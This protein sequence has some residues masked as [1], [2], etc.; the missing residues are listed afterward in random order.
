LAVVPA[1]EH[2]AEHLALARGQPLEIAGEAGLALELRAPLGA[3]LRRCANRLHKQLVVERLLDEVEGSAL[4]R[5]SRRRD[6]AVRGQHHDWPAEPPSRE[7]A[8][9]VDARQAGHPQ[10]E[11]HAVGGLRAR[12]L[13][14]RLARRELARREAMQAQ[15]QR[16][17]IAHG[18]VVV[19]DRDQRGVAR[20]HCASGTVKQNA[21]PGA[22]VSCQ[23]RPPC[24]S[25]IER[26]I[27]SPSPVPLAFVI[28][29][30]SNSASAISGEIPGPLS[31]T[32]MR[33][34]PGPSGAAVTRTT[35]PSDRASSASTAL[36]SRLCS[37]ASICTRSTATGRA[38]PSGVSSVTWL[39][40]ARSRIVV[41]AS[42][43]SS[44]AATVSI[45]TVPERKKSRKRRTTR[46]ARLASPMTLFIVVLT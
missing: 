37:T 14:K 13:E 32:A 35:R 25:T 30:G 19:D 39:R 20:R 12:P 4:E 18:V 21:L 1:G 36:A 7:L 29:N 10:V 42:C 34:K 3:A 15:Q 40:S 27:A 5:R 17:R 45:C 9:H 24:A 44:D 33:T 38:S 43:A 8:L 46:P 41:Q 26:L 22:R 31:S 16:E 23:R 6:V 2:M 28:T 11:Q